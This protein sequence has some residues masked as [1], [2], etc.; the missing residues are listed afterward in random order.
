[1][2][3]PLSSLSYSDSPTSVLLIQSDGK[4]YGPPEAECYPQYVNT[5]SAKKAQTFRTHV[6]N[7]WKKIKINVECLLLN[8]MLQ[9]QTVTSRGDGPR[10]NEDILVN[11]EKSRPKE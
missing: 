3:I 7:K 4:R 9:N 2:Y 1:M 8:M 6:Q 5:C 11:A 10:I